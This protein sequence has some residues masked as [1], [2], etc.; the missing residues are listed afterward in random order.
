MKIIHM[1]RIQTI[2]IL[3]LGSVSFELFDKQ[4]YERLKVDNDGVYEAK[5]GINMSI[6]NQTWGT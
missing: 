2:M 6:I 5:T 4:T 1:K 3:W